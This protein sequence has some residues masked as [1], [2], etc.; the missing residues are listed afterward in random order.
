MD[1][2]NVVLKRLREE[3]CLTQRELAVAAGLSYETIRSFEYGRR[4]PKRVVLIRHLLAG[5]DIEP[6]E[7]EA[8]DLYSA[9]LY[10]TSGHIPTPGDIAQRML[11]GTIS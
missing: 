7:P 2:F 4:H 6:T 5:L 10:A 9:W 3:Q 8:D 11:S 1:A